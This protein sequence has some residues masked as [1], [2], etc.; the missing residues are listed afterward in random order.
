MVVGFVTVKDSAVVEPNLTAVARV[1]PAPLIVTVVPPEVDPDCGVNAVI[2]V[3]N[4]GLA[5]FAAVNCTGGSPV[6]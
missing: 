1:N 5:Q 2:V 6:V 4:S 3:A